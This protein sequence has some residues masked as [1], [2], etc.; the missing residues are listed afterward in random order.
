[1]PSDSDQVAKPMR[2]KISLIANRRKSFAA[3]LRAH[4]YSYRQIG[5]R[6]GVTKGRARQL[7][8]AHRFAV[9]RSLMLSGFKQIET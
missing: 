3:C 7:V 1:M 4:G 6:F 5:Q 9:A 2:E 8:M